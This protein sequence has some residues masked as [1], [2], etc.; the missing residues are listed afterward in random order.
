[1]RRL[2]GLTRRWNRNIRARSVSDGG[3]SRCR[4]WTSNT[5]DYQVSP[6]LIKHSFADRMVVKGAH[7]HAYPCQG[8]IGGNSTGNDIQGD[9]DAIAIAGLSLD[10]AA[11]CLVFFTEDRHAQ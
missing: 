2:H 5:T 1:Q 7:G 6:Y 8:Y 10:D 4:H 11:I 3:R 9:A